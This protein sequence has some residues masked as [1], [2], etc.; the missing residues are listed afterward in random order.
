MGLTAARRRGGH[1]TGGSVTPDSATNVTGIVDA[2]RP[3]VGSAREQPYPPGGSLGSEKTGN[4]RKIW[5]CGSW[6]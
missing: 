2:A 6:R 4:S 1:S 5:L 3:N